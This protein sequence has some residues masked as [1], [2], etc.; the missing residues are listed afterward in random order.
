ML[1][2]P[3]QVNPEDSKARSEMRSLGWI[4]IGLNVAMA[5]L[6]C[7]C[8][9]VC[10]VRDEFQAATLIGFLF[11]QMLVAAVWTTLA[12]VK[13]PTRVLSGTAFVLFV[14]A[15]MYVCADRD[16]GGTDAAIAF[17]GSMLV[18]WWIYLIPLW[19]MRAQGW[20]L[21]NHSTHSLERRSEFQFGIKHLLIWTTVVALLISIAR[22]IAPADAVDSIEIIELIQFVFRMT[23]GNSLI[24]IPIVW[25]CLARH[26]FWLWIVIALLMCAL[27]CVCQSLFMPSQPI[28]DGFLWTISIAQTVVSIV[29][30]LS[31]R[32]TGY[33]LFRSA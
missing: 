29:V 3:N 21:G 6:A 8:I 14:C 31:M 20:R 2:I 22:W 16:G 28:N 32:L 12:P 1:P 27:V 11:V 24:A 17:S 30:M 4:P 9:L 26:Y 13:L 25:G 19:L 33:R 10:E 5:I 15:C 18:Q 7:L 23:L